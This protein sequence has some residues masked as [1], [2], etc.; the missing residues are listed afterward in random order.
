MNEAH[1]HGAKQIYP[2]LDNALPFRLCRIKKIEDF[3]IAEINYKEKINK[4]LNTYFTLPYYA[5]KT[6]LVLPDAGSGVSLCLFSTAVSKPIGIAN[7]S[8]SLV[9]PTGN[10]ILK[11]CLKTM[12]RKRNNPRKIDLQARSKLNSIE[13][14]I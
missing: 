4:T 5:D 2:Q 3:F 10:G 9:F 8:I 6:L 7:A 1:V 13:K 11:I 14:M 12:G